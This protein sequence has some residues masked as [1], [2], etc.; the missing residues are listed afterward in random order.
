[1]ADKK[2]PAPSFRPNLRLSHLVYKGPGEQR[3]DPHGKVAREATGDD[4][5]KV[6]EV[7]RGDNQRTGLSFL[8]RRSR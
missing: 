1:M 8:L 5:D 6:V 3:Y 7:K 2:R 4:D